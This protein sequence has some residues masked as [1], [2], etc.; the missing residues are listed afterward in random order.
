M[1]SDVKLLVR[2]VRLPDSGDR[3]SDI[4]IEGSQIAQISDHIDVQPDV[5]VEP[6]H[7]AL[8]LPGLVDAHCHLDKTLV[9]QPWH[10]HV[11]GTGVADRVRIDHSLRRGLGMPSV[12]NTTAL[13]AQMIANGTTGARTHT[14][15]DSEVGIAGV[16]AVAEV[17]QKFEHAI[18]IEQVAFPQSGML[19]EPGIDRLLREAVELGATV[20]GGLDPAGAE[21]DPV[22]HLDRVFALAHETGCGIDLHL[23]DPGELGAWELELICERTRV[24]SMAGR[25]NI[26]HAIALAQVG[27][28]RQGKLI[29]NLADAGI[30]LTTCVVHNNP[31]LPMKRIVESGVLLSGGN[32]SIRNTWSSLGTGD[33]LERAW[34]FAMRGDL[35][36]DSELAMALEIASNNGLRLL[37]DKGPVGVTVG[38]TANFFLVDAVNT[39][40]AIARRPERKLVVHKGNIVAAADSHTSF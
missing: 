14:E 6:A 16:E 12:A 11:S 32:D 2:G 9:G 38:A 1:S 18:T 5:Q 19:R 31:P 39:G 17:A 36:T 26:S 15:I 35:R 8:V 33:M 10:S 28:A 40:D 22:E 13:V 24:E 7:G 37:G 3:T 20:I 4:L 21:N 23:H 30:S 34:I 29:D 25:V 27:E